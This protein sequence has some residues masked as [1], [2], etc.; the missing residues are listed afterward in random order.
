MIKFVETRIPE[1]YEILCAVNEIQGPT[2]FTEAFVESL[3]YTME[4]KWLPLKAFR[5]VVWEESQE[6][7]L[8]LAYNPKIIERSRVEEI[9][10]EIRNFTHA[11]FPKVKILSSS[12]VY[13]KIRTNYNEVVKINNDNIVHWNFNVSD[14]YKP[15]LLSLG[16]N[17]EEVNQEIDMLKSLLNYKWYRIKRNY[18]KKASMPDDIDRFLDEFICLNRD[19]SLQRVIEA[20]KTYH[21]FHVKKEKH[22]SKEYETQ[23]KRQALDEKVKKNEIQIVDTTIDINDYDEFLRWFPNKYGSEDKWLTIMELLKHGWN[24][25]HIRGYKEENEFFVFEGDM[26]NFISDSH[27]LRFWKIG[28]LLAA[29]QKYLQ[30]KYEKKHPSDK[31]KKVQIL[32]EVTRQQEIE[33]D[34]K[35]KIRIDI[36]MDD[37]EDFLDFLERRDI[38]RQSRKR[39]VEVFKDLYKNGWNE[40]KHST[41]I[42]NNRYVVDTKEIEVFVNGL[43]T[44]DFNVT[45]KEYEESLGLYLTYRWEKDYQRPKQE[46]KEEAVKPIVK[47]REKSEKKQTDNPANSDGKKI[48]VN[49]AHMDEYKSSKSKSEKILDDASVIYVGEPEKEHKNKT[50]QV[51]S[52]LEDDEKVTVSINFSKKDKTTDKEKELKGESNVVKDKEKEPSSR[53]EP[54]AEES[55]EKNKDKA[56]HIDIKEGKTSIF[57][58]IQVFFLHF[59]DLVQLIYKNVFGKK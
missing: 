12:D 3:F 35:K 2:V 7:R 47:V 59:G 54:K 55:F 5:K 57:K 15:Y 22:F 26:R 36:V 48:F 46:I 14:Y 45:L 51:S 28:S 6:E 13:P 4:E 23:K 1:E 38:N 53:E 34:F 41:F 52:I 21:S 16:K 37:L 56:T 30:F 42:D 27:Y 11:F 39:Y 17:E 9:E 19:D 33:L 40:Y 43:K 50:M 49:I 10:T 44:R 25:K 18:V 8:Y 58:L 31:T 29:M 20:Y 32:N 24:D